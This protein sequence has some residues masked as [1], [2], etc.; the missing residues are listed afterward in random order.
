MIKWKQKEGK[1]AG[2]GLDFT[3]PDF[4]V[5][6]QAHGAHK[7]TGSML[8]Q[9]FSPLLQ[10][11]PSSK[12]VHVIDVPLSTIAQGSKPQSAAP[13]RQRWKK[14]KTKS[15]RPSQNM[16]SQNR[17]SKRQENTEIPQTGFA[18]L[19]PGSD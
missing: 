1:Q 10:R 2:F 15:R 17:Q 16:T 11:C 7:G 9:S 4:V 6:A 18:T 12:G 3:N 8:L 19:H 5:L 14:H 13:W